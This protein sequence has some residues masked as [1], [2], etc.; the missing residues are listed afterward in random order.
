MTVMDLPHGGLMSDQ[1]SAAVRAGGL[2]LALGAAGVVATCVLY[3]ISPPQ[4]AMPLVP[5]DLAAALTGAIQGAGTMHLAGLV[6]V[7]GDVLVAAAA[8]L[9]GQFE[10]A[11]GRGVA[12]MGWFLIAVSTVLFAIVD[13]IV[14]FALSQTARQ[15]PAAFPAIKNLFDA[16]F[17]LGTATFGLGAILA[18]AAM[19]TGGVA[20]LL[21]GLAVIAGVFVPASRNHDVSFTNGIPT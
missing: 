17:L 7:A 15:A 13:S 10:T 1:G 18:M 16:M 6:G 11:R 20:R 21:A 5:A 14:G 8:L 2:V 3:G 9:L 19:R 12:A 4:A